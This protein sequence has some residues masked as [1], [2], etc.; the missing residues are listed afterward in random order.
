MAD[1]RRHQI[2]DGFVFVNKDKL[3]KQ[4][5]YDTHFC[6][7]LQRYVNYLLK[8]SREKLKDNGV[9][10]KITIKIYDSRFTRLSDWWRFL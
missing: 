5:K 6:I 3:I 4:S 8:D 7:G 1:R 10:L 9:K 2:A